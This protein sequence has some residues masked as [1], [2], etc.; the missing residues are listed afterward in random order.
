MS[1]LS[2]L[3]LASPSQQ[4]MVSG[5]F[6]EKV[7]FLDPFEDLSPE[8]PDCPDRDTLCLARERVK[9]YLAA[10]RPDVVFGHGGYGTL[11][12]SLLT[13]GFTFP[14][15]IISSAMVDPRSALALGSASPYTGA[16]SLDHLLHT[17]ADNAAVSGINHVHMPV[18]IVHG[19]EDPVVPSSQADELFVL[20]KA[21]QKDVYAKLV[22]VPGC[23]HD[24]P[25]EILPDLRQEIS[26][27]LA[28]HATGKEATEP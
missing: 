22:L 8:H 9:D 18:L 14:C 7:Y 6:P 27:F 17:L 26:G 25:P 5:L 12:L 4:A 15:A 21:V 24:Y 10:A 3:A 23:G 16:S 20:L 28:S 13:H 2:C 1:S 11:V 19:E